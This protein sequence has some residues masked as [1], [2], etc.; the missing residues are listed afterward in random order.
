MKAGRERTE[1]GG[2][3]AAKGGLLQSGGDLRSHPGL[4][5]GAWEAAGRVKPP[6]SARERGSGRVG[7]P[8]G[9]PLTS[10]GAA[11]RLPRSAPAAAAFPPSL[12]NNKSQAP[13]LS[14]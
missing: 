11:R 5:A 13:S 8:E 4:V 10:P 9:V 1:A 3:D 2:S 12:V 7:P 14:E 6:G